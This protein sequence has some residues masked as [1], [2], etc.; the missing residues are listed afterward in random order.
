M[1]DSGLLGARGGQA[2]RER[3]RERAEINLQTAMRRQH[4][5]A[6]VG[7]LAC[8]D[9]QLGQKLTPIRGTWLFAY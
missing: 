7:S 2:G 4:S 3:E 8:E 5:S 6:K 1:P 9:V